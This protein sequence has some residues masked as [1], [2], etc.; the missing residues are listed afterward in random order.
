MKIAAT[1]ILLAM[2]GACATQPPG[3][4]QHQPGYCIT[5]PEACK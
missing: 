2:L 3:H 4:T 1:I 5:H